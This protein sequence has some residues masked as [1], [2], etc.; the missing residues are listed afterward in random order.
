VKSFDGINATDYQFDINDLTK[1]VYLVKAFDSQNR[2]KTMK[3]IK[4]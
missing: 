1:G 2:T 3:L 4:Q